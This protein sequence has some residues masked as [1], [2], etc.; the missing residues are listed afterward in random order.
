MLRTPL[1]PEIMRSR[2]KVER[3]SVIIPFKSLI[4]LWLRWVLI[5]VH[6]LPL[7]VAHRC[8]TAVAFVEEHRL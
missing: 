6:R 1:L 5:A 2:R 4:N 8:L 7:V 3:K